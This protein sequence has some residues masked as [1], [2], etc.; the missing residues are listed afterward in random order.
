[1]CPAATG[2]VFAPHTTGDAHNRASLQCNMHSTSRTK[3]TK[4]LDCLFS[5]SQGAV[6]GAIAKLYSVCNDARNAANL[7][8]KS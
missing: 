3:R 8:Q 6:Q 2:S 1:M 7:V 5:R 4:V